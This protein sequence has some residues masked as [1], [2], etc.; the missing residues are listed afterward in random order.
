MRVLGKNVLVKPEQEKQMNED[1][2]LILSSKLKFGNVVSVGTKVKNITSGDRI[3]LPK[4]DIIDISWK[5]ID[6]VIVNED[7][8]VACI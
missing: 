3:L 7:N 6:Y 4:R 8:I 5:G 2:I 1:G